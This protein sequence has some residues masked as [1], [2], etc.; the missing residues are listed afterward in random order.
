MRASSRIGAWLGAVLVVTLAC[1]KKEPPATTAG[2]PSGAPASE[3]A[4]RE[5]LTTASAPYAAVIAGKGYRVVQAKRFPAQVD[6]RRA[7]VVVYQSDDGARGGILYVRGFQDDPPLPAWHWYFS[8]AAPDSAVAVDLNRDG[9]WDVRVHMRGGAAREF[10]QDVDFS[11]TGAERSGLVAM[12]GASSSPEGLWKAFDADTSTAWNAPAPDAYLDIPNP[13]GLEAGQ[14]SV[15]LA[16]GSQPKKLE[17]G[18]GTRTLQ[19]CDLVTG[20]EEQRFQL[21]PAVKDLPVVRVH[22]IGRGKSVALSELE[23]R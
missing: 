4:A 7:Y 2:K 11:F 12:N 22:L 17:I 13:F 10:V 14:L 9:L 8:D 18:D 15:R 16:G 6:A 19:E 1:G 3:R 21:D 5:P 20:T 23:L